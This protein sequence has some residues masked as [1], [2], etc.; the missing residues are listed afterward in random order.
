MSRI[1]SVVRVSASHSLANRHSCST[2][3]D[4][5]DR[6]CFSMQ[7]AAHIGGWQGGYDQSD[8]PDVII[9]LKVIVSLFC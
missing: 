7:I 9:L 8:L 1:G 2:S 4:T 5:Q 3:A 6:K